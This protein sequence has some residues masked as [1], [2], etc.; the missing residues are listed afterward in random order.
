MRIY[1]IRNA[2]ISNSVRRT[3]GHIQN[4]RRT[5]VRIKSGRYF[6]AARARHLVMR[7]VSP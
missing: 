6:I 4:T 2:I 7:N 1:R 5:H 3:R